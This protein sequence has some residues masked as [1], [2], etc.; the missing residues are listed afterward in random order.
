MMGEAS[1]RKLAAAGKAW[2]AATAR[3]K[4]LA[5]RERALARR[6]RAALAWLEG[7]RAFSSAI[8]AA[9]MAP[10]SEGGT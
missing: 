5:R 3:A 8:S 7:Y 2:R 9:A 4:R 1:S 6:R 10:C